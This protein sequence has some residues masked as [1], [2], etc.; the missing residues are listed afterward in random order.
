MCSEE[1]YELTSLG[2]PPSLQWG[3]PEA[4][5]ESQIAGEDSFLHQ[6]HWLLVKLGLKTGNVS[7][8]DA[9]FAED[10]PGCFCA[11]ARGLSQHCNQ[12]S[13]PLPSQ[14]GSPP[15]PHEPLTSEKGS[16]FQDVSN[17]EADLRETSRYVSFA[18]NNPVE[19]PA[20]KPA[21][22]REGSLK[23]G[24]GAAAGVHGRAEGR[25]PMVGE[26]QSPTP[27]FSAT[28]DEAL[29][30]QQEGGPVT[31]HMGHSGRSLSLPQLP[32]PTSAPSQ[33]T[34]PGAASLAEPRG[35]WSVSSS[36]C[37]QGP[38]S[39]SCYT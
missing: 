16:E 4:G 18:S 21:A 22:T 2:K 15:A 37:P 25:R 6:H 12:Q 27:G 7:K 5:L 10:N 3:P 35:T 36:G 1:G 33:A 26:G 17:A 31:P 29:S 32:W 19:A 11:P 23:G 9:A 14:R 24:A 30:S 20:R 34:A 8:I 28:A 13:T 39:S 38:K